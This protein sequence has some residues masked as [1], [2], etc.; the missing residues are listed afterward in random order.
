MGTASLTD[1]KPFF[2]Q[3]ATLAPHDGLSFDRTML[4]GSADCIKI[5]SVDGELLAMN[6]TGCL[7]LG[8]PDEPRFGMAWTS[9]LPE[10][11]RAA[12]QEAIE[13]ARQGRNARFPGRS[14]QAGE[15]R[16]W[17][18]LLTPVL[19]EEGRVQ[20][21]LCVSRDVTA[22]TLLERELEAALERERLLAREMRHRIKNVFAVMSGLISLSQ[23]EASGSAALETCL[24]PLRERIDAFARASEVIFRPRSVEAGDHDHVDIALIVRSVLEPYDDRYETEGE[25]CVIPGQ[26]MTVL[27]LYLHELATNCVKY[28]A[29]STDEGIVRVGWHAG[30]GGLSLTWA[31]SGVPASGGPPRGQGFGSDMID[32]LV[33]S[34]G[35]SIAKTWSAQ[36]LVA[37]LRVPVSC[38]P[39]S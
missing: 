5:I 22:M 15:T 25:P 37:H 2:P 20:V 23:R 7:A 30:A 36:G 14:G 1:R 35:G 34:S 31:E 27:V 21:I 10:C 4:D 24:R 6:R 8:L 17:D 12:G 16:Y 9:L 3:D 13:T 11:V 28:G 32:R 38:A 29:F 19:D 18:N 33:K 26:L 39:G